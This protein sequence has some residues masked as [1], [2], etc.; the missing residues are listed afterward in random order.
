[1]DILRGLGLDERR[2]RRDGVWVDH[3]TIYQKGIGTSITGRWRLGCSRIEVTNWDIK[4][5]NPFYL[6]NRPFQ[7]RFIYLS[8]GV[9]RLKFEIDTLPDLRATFKMI[10][11]IL[12]LTALATGAAA[13]TFSGTAKI[14][15]AW[16]G[17]ACGGE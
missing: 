17:T 10:S 4:Y 8:P 15:E 3:Q 1:M 5:Q 11:S 16:S 9:K 12:I 6:F 13:E 7:S 2:V 14:H